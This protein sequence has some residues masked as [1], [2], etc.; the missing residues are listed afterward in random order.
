MRPTSIGYMPAAAAFVLLS[1]PAMAA[2]WSVD[3]YTIDPGTFHSAVQYDAA[4]DYVLVVQ[5]HEESRVFELYVESPFDWETDASYAPEVPAV[6]T[7]DG[8]E[9]T[10][11]MFY[12]DDRQMGEG[13]RADNNTAAFKALLERLLAAKQPIEL[14][15]FDR[16]TAFSAEGIDD[17]LHA[18]VGSCL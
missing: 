4:G 5:C 1:S 6:L 17:A 11:V 12:F 9:V 8:V 18:L 3:S 14:S 10:D 2:P 7:I 16:S 13:I 15:F